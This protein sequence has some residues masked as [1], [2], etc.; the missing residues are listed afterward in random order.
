MKLNGTKYWHQHF[1]D[2]KLF[3]KI[4]LHELLYRVNATLESLKIIREV[5]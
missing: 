1:S 5:H 2:L 4:S 3:D